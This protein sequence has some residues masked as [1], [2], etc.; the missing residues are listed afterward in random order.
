[1]DL[2]IAI[3]NDPG[4]IFKHWALVI[5]NPT[6]NSDSVSGWN[7]QDYVLELLDALEQEGVVDGAYGG[8]V[9]RKLI[10]G[11]VDTMK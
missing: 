2:S 1:M 3:L 6:T 7:C 5:P 4:S 11:G 9:K 8:Y 10:S